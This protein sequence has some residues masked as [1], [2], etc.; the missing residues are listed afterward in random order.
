MLEILNALGSRHDVRCWRNPVGAAAFPKGR[1]QL[2]WRRFGLVGSPD[3]IGFVRGG[4]FLGIEVKSE[5]RGATT[6]QA[7][8][9]RTAAAFGCCCFI[10]R[11]VDEAVRNVDEFLARHTTTLPPAS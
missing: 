8:F 5:T 7:S 10:A 2:V 11:S 6:E 4:W 3:I 1:D 9:L